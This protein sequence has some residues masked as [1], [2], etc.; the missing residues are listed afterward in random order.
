MRLWHSDVDVASEVD[1]R[2]T[3]RPAH[4]H[5]EPSSPHCV[6]RPTPEVLP[7]LDP[8][9][10]EGCRVVPSHDN[11]HDRRRA[12]AYGGPDVALVTGTL[13]EQPVDATADRTNGCGISDWDDLLGAVLPN[14]I[15]VTG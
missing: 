13:D 8:G 9:T 10:S 6:V 2:P 1:R 4:A 7:W 15:G 11:R 3:D 5:H 14:P 12:T